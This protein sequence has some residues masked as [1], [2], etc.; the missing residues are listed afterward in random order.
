MI[1]LLG[2]VIKVTSE[3]GKGTAFT[4]TVPCQVPALS[5]E[6]SIAKPMASTDT[7]KLLVL[8]AEDEESNYLYMEVV[9]KMLGVKHIHAINGA[10]AVE[11]C[12]QNGKIALVLMDIKMPVMNGLEATQL[13]HEF[14]PEL[15]II[16]TT[17]Y[18]QTGDEHRF[19]AAGCN[20]YLAKPVKKENLLLL[21]QKYAQV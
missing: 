19:L 4:F 10:E 6:P 7:G 1:K 3:K 16:A 2:G 12:K 18:A 15:P 5:E 9:M 20:G 11:M 17:A 8:I 14:R 21:L 13:I